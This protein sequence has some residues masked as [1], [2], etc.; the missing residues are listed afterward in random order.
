[1]FEIN[2]I[3]QNRNVLGYRRAFEN[4]TIFLNLRQICKKYKTEKKIIYKLQK[5]LLS[6]MLCSLDMDKRNSHITICRL[7][8]F[9]PICKFHKIAK[10]VLKH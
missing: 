7:N 2:Y 1:M 5:I 8:Y 10:M 6:E 4:Y 3:I 9:N